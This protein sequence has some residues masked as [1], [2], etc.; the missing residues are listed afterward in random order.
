MTAS[1][2]QLWKEQ[3]RTEA[4]RAWL[5]SLCTRKDEREDETRGESPPASTS[6]A[7]RGLGSKVHLMVLAPDIIELIICCNSGVDAACIEQRQSLGAIAA[8]LSRQ[9]A[10][11]QTQAPKVIARLVDD[12]TEKID[13]LTKELKQASQ[14]AQYPF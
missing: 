14:Q 13:E 9:L 2:S 11:E 7:V 10:V 1:V 12:S 8:T 6:D 5:S 3:G 4:F